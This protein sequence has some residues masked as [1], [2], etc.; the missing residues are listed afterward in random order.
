MENLQLGLN[1]LDLAAIQ[2]MALVLATEY[3]INILMALA[4]FFIG[5][6]V[7]KRIVT[8]LE[9][10]ML[11]SKLD[12]TLVKFAD[13]VIYALLLII[14]VIA[15]L[16]QLGV[17]TT[18]LAAMLAAA[19][20]AIGLALQGSLSNLAAG[21]MIIL[22]R[23]FK[24][25]D[26]VQAGGTE[27]KVEEISIFTTNFVTPD[28]KQVIVPNNEITAGVITNFTTKKQRRVDLVIG[29]SYDDDLAQTRKVI[30]KVITAESRILK[31][32]E[33]RI[34]VSNLGESS[35]D[36]VVRPWVKT[37]DYWDVKFDLIENIKVALDKAGITIPYPQRDL[38]I[39]EG[40]APASE[41]PKKSE[42][43]TTKKTA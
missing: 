21:V 27:G 3:G 17:D 37:D 13:D 40:T 16:N 38:H 7:A 35:V 9:K 1:N 12:V 29:V 42:K 4:T 23:P 8:I 5:K 6:W 41:K 24:V 28:N 11:K 22:F 15:A 31:D 43:K 18:H 26:Y 39:I 25:N 32:P 34:A 36:F 19:G 14:I 10:L 30:A 20:L 33:T 2:K